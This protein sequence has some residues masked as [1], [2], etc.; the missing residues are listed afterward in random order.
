[1]AMQ[2]ICDLFPVLQE[3]R[4]Q[5]SGTLSGGEQQM[6]SIGRALMGAPNL[7]LLDEPF[8]GLAPKVIGEILGS[9]ERLRRKGL[10]ILL[11]EQNARA[12]LSIA[13]NGFVM[14]EGFIVAS[15][16][17]KELITSAKVREIYFGEN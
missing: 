9:L 10:T 4:R 12:A 14:D 15:G 16:A 11:A 2:E 13:D 3:R 17:A 6:L 5:K 8:L 7:L 1:R